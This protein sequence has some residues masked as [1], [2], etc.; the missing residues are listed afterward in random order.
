MARVSK[1]PGRTKFNTEYMPWLEEDEIESNDPLEMERLP[2]APDIIK[3]DRDR[4][5]KLC[6]EH[7]FPFAKLNKEYERKLKQANQLRKRLDE[8]RIELN[9]TWYSRG[10]TERRKK[11]KKE[12][13]ELEKMIEEIMAID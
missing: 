5:S 3:E 13:A 12:M 1:V 8:L 11:I 6:R 7:G 2:G 10:A 9:M 4:F